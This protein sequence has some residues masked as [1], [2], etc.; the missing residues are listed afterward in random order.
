MY[1]Y[2]E[3]LENLTG[4]TEFSGRDSVDIL[5]RMIYSEAGNQ[6]EEGKRGV[7]FVAAN[8]KAKNSTSFGGGTYE[9]VI[10]KAGQFAGMTTSAARNPDLTSQAW[11]ESL[12]IASSM[13]T[14]E[15]PIGTCLWFMTPTSYNS[16]MT[17]ANGNE[18]VNFGA[19]AVKVT[20]KYTIGDHV[21]FNLMGY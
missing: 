11:T 8:R 9:G 13:S 14:A 7:A 15:N 20:E 18:Y 2:G 1:P 16:I 4:L 3:P 17:T 21:F 12:D 6:S 5:A 19:G 10:L